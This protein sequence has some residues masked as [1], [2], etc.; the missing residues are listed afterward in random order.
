MNTQ[1]KLIF[2][3]FCFLFSFSVPL[4]SQRAWAGS[5]GRVLVFYDQLST[6][7]SENQVSF[8]AGNAHGT[9]KVPLSFINRVR[10]YNPAFKLLHYELAWGAGDIYNLEGSSWVSD[11]DSINPNES[12]FL[13]NAG[14]RCHQ[15]DWDWDLMDMSGS[16]GGSVPGWKEY[17]ARRAIRRMRLNDCDGIFADSHN[18]PWNMDYYPEGFAPPD[19][20]GLGLAFNVFDN[21]VMSALHSDSTNYKYIPNIGSWVTGWD[22]TDYSNCDGI[23]IENFSTWD[24]WTHYD[25]EDWVLFVDRAL[26]MANDNKIII[27]QHDCDFWS[28]ECRMWFIANYFMVKNSTTYIN[29]ILDPDGSWCPHG[30]MNPFWLGEYEIDLGSFSGEIP[31]N[32]ASMFNASWG[33]YVRYYSRGMVLVN[34]SWSSRTATFGGTYY[35]LIPEGGGCVWEDGYTDE[36]TELTFSPTSSVTLSPMSAEIITYTNGLWVFLK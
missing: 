32:A 35:R 7:L 28:P 5:E 21:Y 31:L 12:W 20:G 14:R 27:L 34:N 16:F 29:L 4:F 11:W 6:G 9:Q 26:S 10:A 19:D 3:I 36:P 2:I 30:S 22:N 25:P 15:L 33:L 18:M 24:C 8:V 1:R 13:H 23:M 17:W